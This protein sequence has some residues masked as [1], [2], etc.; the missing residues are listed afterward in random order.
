[1]R[2]VKPGWRLH[3]KPPQAIGGGSAEGASESPRRR[4]RPP[5]FSHFANIK[6]VNVV[7]KRGLLELT[8]DKPEALEEAVAWHRV[9][10]AADWRNLMD[11][12]KDFPSAGRVGD[13]LVF[14]LRHNRYRLIVRAAFRI[15]TLFV[16]TLLTHKEY[17]REEWKKWA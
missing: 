9:A 3:K 14:N 17:D 15:R 5:F 2:P 6:A 8:R 12:R 11:V 13:V 7:S 16:K 10:R 4:Y 1:M